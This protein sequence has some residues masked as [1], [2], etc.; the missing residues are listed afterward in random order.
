MDQPLLAVTSGE[1]ASLLSTLLGV[2]PT[3]APPTDA[4]LPDFAAVL[5]A[6]SGEAAMNGDAET[7]SA[8]ITLPL[9][10]G[11]NSAALQLAPELAGADTEAAAGNPPPQTGQSLPPALRLL[12]PVN[13]PPTPGATPG[14]GADVALAAVP[15]PATAASAAVVVAEPTRV[16]EAPADFADVLLPL[17]ADAQR[18]T[19][20]RAP[21][22]ARVT[23]T[24]RPVTSGGAAPQFA[25]ALE[26]LAEV[27]L[28]VAVRPADAPAGNVQPQPLQAEP[29]AALSTP[30]PVADP[31][32]GAAN[33]SATL[34]APKPEMILPVPPQHQNWSQAFAERVTFAVTQQ[35]Q[36]AELRL[37]PPQLGQ[38]EVRISLQQDQASLLFTSPH[39][40]VRDAIEAS[41][42]RLRESLSEGGFN[43]VNVDVSDKSLAQERRGHEA[44]RWF[45]RASGYGGA[46]AEYELAPDAAQRVGHGGDGRIDCFA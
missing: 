2:A 28:P 42:G 10:I 45:G 25:P 40:A 3:S 4:A 23:T 38:I 36:E 33:V 11:L 18:T 30:S 41:L 27:L 17:N 32:A 39:G 19:P 15:V 7:A 43:L 12:M 21:R 24:A 13:S 20:E 44:E 34:S 26:A 31:A 29:P 9:P 16:A 37:N 22:D 6:L 5:Q 8:P 1:A 14:T 46:T 35:M